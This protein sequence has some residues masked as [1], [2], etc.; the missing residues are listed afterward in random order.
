MVNIGV[1]FCQFYYFVVVGEMTD[2]LSAARYVEIDAGPD[3]DHCLLCL[4]SVLL[5]WFVINHSLDVV[6]I[7]TTVT[8]IDPAF[9]CASKVNVS[10]LILIICALVAHESRQPLG[11]S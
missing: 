7:V 1:S 9:H 11:C 10:I 5:P 4:S 2:Y 3:S 8:I 6:I